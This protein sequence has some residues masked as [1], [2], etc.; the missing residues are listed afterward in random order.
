MAKIRD[1][2]EGSIFQ[3]KNGKWIGEFHIGTKTNGRAK[4][5]IF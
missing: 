3:R 5:K 1:K 2:G 4:V